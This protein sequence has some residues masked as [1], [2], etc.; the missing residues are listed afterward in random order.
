MKEANRMKLDAVGVSEVRCTGERQVSS[1]EWTFYYC[2]EDRHEAGVGILLKI[3]MA[4]A[5]VGC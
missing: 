3:E 5:V 1:D 4:D 2:G